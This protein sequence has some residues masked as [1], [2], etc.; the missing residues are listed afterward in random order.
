MKRSWRISD[1]SW[2]P[3][4]RAPPPVTP[5]CTCH[6]FLCLV[7]AN[8]L[9]FIGTAFAPRCLR[10]ICLYGSFDVAGVD[11]WKRDSC[12]EQLACQVV[13][14]P[15]IYSSP[16]PVPGPGPSLPCSAPIPI[17]NKVILACL[18][19]CSPQFLWTAFSISITR[20]KYHWVCT[21]P[22]VSNNFWQAI[23][24]DRIYFIRSPFTAHLILL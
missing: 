8:T 17:W 1:S 23:S 6:L 4:S 12:S 10:Q 20:V 15:P 14:L 22:T 21:S 19:H 11:D 24:A 13:V 5:A 9:Q 2:N 7:R 18:A 3:A 16:V